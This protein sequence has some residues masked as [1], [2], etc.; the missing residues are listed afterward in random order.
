[1][2]GVNRRESPHRRAADADA[3]ADADAEKLVPIA[4]PVEAYAH[5]IPRVDATR[6]RS[7]CYEQQHS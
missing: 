5:V 7:K 6:E 4:R 2:A 3:D 1:M